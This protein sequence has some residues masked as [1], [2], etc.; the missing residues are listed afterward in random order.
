[1]E[2]EPPVF[3]QAFAMSYTDPDYQPLVPDW[4]KID[5]VA[6]RR[7]GWTQEEI[8]LVVNALGAA[9]TA[10][11]ASQRQR[12]PGPSSAHWVQPT[13]FLQRLE[14][15]GY[16]TVSV[17]RRAELR[18]TVQGP[19]PWLFLGKTTLTSCAESAVRDALRNRYGAGSFCLCSHGDC[20]PLD[21]KGLPTGEALA[22]AVNT[23]AAYLRERNVTVDDVYAALHTLASD[24]KSDTVFKA[25]VLGVRDAAESGVTLELLS[26]LF[27]SSL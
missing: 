22:K 6:A 18:V 5:F 26:D 16:R 12:H 11:I 3:W 10:A 23:V 7:A 14:T 9:S 24:A 1:L 21:I 25:L 20:T 13:V 15:I 8:T 19:R 17:Y 27:R 4:I 2:A